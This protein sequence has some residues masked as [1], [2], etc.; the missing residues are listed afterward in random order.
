MPG[1]LPRGS[2]AFLLQE[3]LAGLRP[4]DPGKA[5]VSA[6]FF[7]RTL[8]RFLGRPDLLLGTRR[9]SEPVLWSYALWKAE[10]ADDR[11]ASDDNKRAFTA[12]LYRHEREPP[13]LVRYWV[14]LD[15]AGRIRAS[16]W[17]GTAPTLF[18][19]DDAS[20]FAPAPPLDAAAVDAVLR[21]LEAND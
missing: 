4:P 2:G 12:R 13:E 19:E 18:D 17:I 14:K 11:D 15:G 16:G 6:G 5:V 20:A 7:H 1:R 9:K 21:D 3:A 10:L 8:A